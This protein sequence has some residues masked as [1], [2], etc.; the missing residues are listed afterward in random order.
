MTLA[1]GS[2]AM[3]FNGVQPEIDSTG[4]ANDLFRRVASRVDLID[5][6]FPFPN[7]AIETSGNLCKDFSVTNTNYIPANSDGSTTCQP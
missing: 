3:N 4:R 1:N 6:N 7:G 2:T 5:T